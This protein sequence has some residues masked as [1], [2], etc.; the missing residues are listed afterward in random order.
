M[1]WKKRYKERKVEWYFWNHIGFSTK[2]RQVLCV[3][4]V[5]FSSLCLHLLRT[6]CRPG[7]TFYAK[8]CSDLLFHFE[9]IWQLMKS[10]EL[11]Y[12]KIASSWIWWRGGSVRLVVW[13]LLSLQFTEPLAYF[14]HVACEIFA[15]W[16][17]IKPLAIEGQ[18]LNYWTTREVPGA[19]SF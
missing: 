19:I 1:E 17:G 3:F 18:S 12:L 2:K 6:Q 11:C 14:C 9:I 16:Q 4:L 8:N 10:L 13:L 5:C 7:I 15:P